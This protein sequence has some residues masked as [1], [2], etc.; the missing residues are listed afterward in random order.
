MKKYVERY[1][2][3]IPLLIYA[4]IYCAWFA[5]LEKRVTHPQTIIHVKFDDAIPFCEIFVIP[6]FLWFVYMGVAVLYCFFKNKQEYYRTCVFLFTGMTIFLII[7]T[8]WPNGHHPVLIKCQETICLPNWWLYYIVWIP[9][10]ISGP[11]SMYITPS[12]RI[13]QSYTTKSLQKIR[14]SILVPFSCVYPLF[15]LLYS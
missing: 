8:F 11:V 12:E 4:V 3:A 6:Y 13:W 14:L 2:H 5:W 1:K 7:S 15:C 10:Q 9:P